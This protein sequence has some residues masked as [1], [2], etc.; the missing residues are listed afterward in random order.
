MTSP[1]TWFRSAKTGPAVRFILG[2]LLTAGGYWLLQVSA[3]LVYFLAIGSGAGHQNEGL[4]VEAGF[5]LLQVGLLSWLFWRGIL[6]ST[7][8]AWAF[9]VTVALSLFSRYAFLPWYTA[10]SDSTYQ[11]YTFVQRGHAYEITLESPDHVF[12]LS[13][14]SNQKNGSTT[15][16]LMGNYQVRHDTIFFHEWAGPRKGFLYNRT[17]VG[18]THSTRPILLTRERDITP[19]TFW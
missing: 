6:Y 3:V 19:W 18:F 17:L 13:D 11:R 7:W 4:V 10:S 1:L 9:N 15:S 16:L 12:N 8:W 5:L 14:V 2:L